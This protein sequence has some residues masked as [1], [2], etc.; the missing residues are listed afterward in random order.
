MTTSRAPFLLSAAL[1]AVLA[2]CGDPDKGEAPKVFKASPP[3]GGGGGDSEAKAYPFEARLVNKGGVEIDA[4]IVGRTS[5]ELI[6]QRRGE[7]KRYRVPLGDVTADGFSSLSQLPLGQWRPDTERIKALRRDLEIL[8]AR[9]VDTGEE[10]SSSQ[11]ARQRAFARQLAELQQERAETE[12]RI[13][14]EFL[15]EYGPE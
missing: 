7:P 14:A 2:G 13:E 15:Q 12:A 10:A 5:S 9:I 4:V 6:F 8:D 11:G 1:F 3:G